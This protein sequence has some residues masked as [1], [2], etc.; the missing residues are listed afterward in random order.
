MW[1]IIYFVLM[2]CKLDSLLDLC[3]WNSKCYAADMTWNFHRKYWNERLRWVLYIVD[4]KC[5]INLCFVTGNKPVCKI[6]IFLQV[7][8]EIHIKNCIFYS[9]QVTSIEL[10]VFGIKFMYSVCRYWAEISYLET[11]SS[12]NLFAVCMLHVIRHAYSIPLS[13]LFR[14]AHHCVESW[15]F[16][17]RYHIF[18]AWFLQ[19]LN[20]S[21]LSWVI[22]EHL[23]T[24]VHKTIVCFYFIQ[25]ISV[26]ELWNGKLNFT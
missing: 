16:F 3:K 18:C 1:C 17:F 11:L 5:H 13:L 6:K 4:L 24:S 23:Y 12:Q 15:D 10:I 19:S 20:V 14:A 22:M 25:W 21:A 9:S 2:L 7:C 26:P 8:P